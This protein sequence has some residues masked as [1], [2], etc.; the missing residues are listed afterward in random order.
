MYVNSPFTTIDL[1]V[2]LSSA[3]GLQ[4][5]S[6]ITRRKCLRA[7]L[8]LPTEAEI[9]EPLI[10]KIG[11]RRGKERTIPSLLSFWLCEDKDRVTMLGI[12]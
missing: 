4:V 8:N 3:S 2:P 7:N 12:I 11:R 6:P 10:S 9:K 5:H 1:C